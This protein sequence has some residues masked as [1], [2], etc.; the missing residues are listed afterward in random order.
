MQMTTRIFSSGFFRWQKIPRRREKG[1]FFASFF[2]P[3]KKD[4]ANLLFETCPTFRR[5]GYTKGVDGRV[6]NILKT[7]NQK[8]LVR[9]TV[10]LFVRNYIY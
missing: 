5:G 2:R 3:G 10:F 4:E 7:T 1:R 8:H 6:E 9:K